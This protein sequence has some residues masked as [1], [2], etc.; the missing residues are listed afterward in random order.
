MNQPVPTNRT[1]TKERKRGIS[2]RVLFLYAVFLSVCWL[3]FSGKFEPLHLGLGAL[4]VTLS[5]YLAYS[6]QRI[7]GSTGVPRIGFI[8]FYPAWLEA[9][10]IRSS[11]KTIGLILSK[12]P[13]EPTALWAEYSD[14]PTS[15]ITAYTHS[16]TLTPGTVSLYVD[17]PRK[18]I[19]VHALTEEDAVGLKSG[20]MLEKVRPLFNCKRNNNE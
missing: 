12:R 8:L 14:L 19:M 6:L 4:S 1:K 9:Q 13:I 3:V 10:I 2:L 11:F 18:R 20:D 5:L 17:V 7:Y 16:I 15:G